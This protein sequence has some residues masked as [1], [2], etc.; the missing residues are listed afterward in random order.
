MC[1]LWGLQEGVERMAAAIEDEVPLVEVEADPAPEVHD[2]REGDDRDRGHDEGRR[3]WVAQGAAEWPGQRQRG[4]GGR[5][6]PRAF[7]DGHGRGV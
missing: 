1:S 3:T 7:L 6:R 4:L 5:P 2:Q